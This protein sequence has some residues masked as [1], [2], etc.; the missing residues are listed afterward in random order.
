[1][2]LVRILAV[3]GQAESQRRQKQQRN[4]NSHNYL[5]RLDVSLHRP[6]CTFD[7]LIRTNPAAGK[8]S[9]ES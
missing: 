1:L 3:S 2:S 8:P 6:G 5:Y 9:A 7:S 4:R